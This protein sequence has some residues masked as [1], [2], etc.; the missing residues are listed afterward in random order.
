[1]PFSSGQ[2]LNQKETRSPGTTLI[3]RQL[4]MARFG[5]ILFKPLEIQEFVT[6]KRTM[7]LTVKLPDE[8][9]EGLGRQADANRRVLEA[10][11]LARYLSEEISLGRLAEL[12]VASRVEAEAFLDRHNARLPY[13][14]QMLEEDRRHLRDALGRR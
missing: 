4:P 8:I 3:L 2:V 5:L 1:L 14:R 13:T 10:L 11:V 6:T 7:E 9:A 12:L